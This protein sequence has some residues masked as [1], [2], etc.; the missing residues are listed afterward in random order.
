MAS[1]YVMTRGINWTTSSK[2]TTGK[3][4]LLLG[5]SQNLFPQNPNGTCSIAQVRVL[6]AF[7]ML[8]SACH[9]G[10]RCHRWY[11]PKHTALILAK[12]CKMVCGRSANEVGIMSQPKDG[13]PSPRRLLHPSPST[14]PMS[15]RLVTS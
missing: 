14:S 4:L 3:D 10:R 6:T 9:T 5:P 1:I 12:Y 15:D 11:A 8:F 7:D 2:N 13:K